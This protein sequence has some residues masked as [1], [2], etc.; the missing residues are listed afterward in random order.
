MMLLL[1]GLIV[2][3]SVHALPANRALRDGLVGRFGETAYKGAFSLVSLA[4]FVMIVLG[5]AKMQELTG[6]KNP[7]LWDPPNWTRHAAYTLMIPAMIL[8]VAAY[9]PSRIR[10]AAKHPMLLAVKIWAL[11]HLIANGDAASLILFGSFL[12]WAIFD[13]ISLKRRGDMGAG[14][15]GATILNDI[16]VIAAGLALY[17]GMLVWGH[18]ALIG[19]PLVSL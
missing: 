9:V 16:I 7:I 6:S 1:M 2:F 8:L 5:Y 11:A 15:G 13:R 19:V 4:G 18:G 12:A 17:A 14:A 3:L 10:A